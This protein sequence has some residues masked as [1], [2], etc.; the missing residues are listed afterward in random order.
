MDELISVQDIG[1]TVAKSIIEFFKEDKIIKSINE[2]MSLGV[3]PYYEEEEILE[4]IF[5]GK[6]VVVTGTLKN[7]SRGSIKEKLESLGAK[8]A[9]SGSG[10]AES[11][12]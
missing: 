3:K 10:K 6:T 11:S 9:G 7:Y 2:L 8:V 12:R 4:S 5:L 1:D